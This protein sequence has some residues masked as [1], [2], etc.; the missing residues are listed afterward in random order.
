MIPTCVYV[1][2]YVDTM[3]TKIVLCSYCNS[4][5]Q[6]ATCDTVVRIKYALDE[7]NGTVASNALVQKEY[8]STSNRKLQ[9]IYVYINFIKAKKL[10]LV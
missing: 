3:S 6:S 10:N 9:Y 7:I 2:I 8:E 1:C 5:E 4:Q